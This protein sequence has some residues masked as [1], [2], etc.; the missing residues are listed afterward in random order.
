MSSLL[1]TTCGQS[2]GTPASSHY[3]SSVVTSSHHY[4]VTSLHHY[5]I[6][7]LQKKNTL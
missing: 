3:P 6:T 4:I 1:Y 5:I 2:S 7:S